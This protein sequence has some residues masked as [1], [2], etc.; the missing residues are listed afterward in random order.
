M[1]NLKEIFGTDSEDE[2]V[3]KKKNKKTSSKRKKRAPTPESEDVSPD[4]ADEGEV[5]IDSG[6][7]FSE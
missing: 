6:S 5:V 3:P 4:E 2:P 1:D 7:E